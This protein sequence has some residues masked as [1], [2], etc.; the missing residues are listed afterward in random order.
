MNSLR[1]ESVEGPNDQLTNKFV[2]RSSWPGRLPQEVSFF[3]LLL[4][5]FVFK[6]YY[7]ASNGQI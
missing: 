3:F 4:K 1:A 7:S 2:K 6:A 5:Y